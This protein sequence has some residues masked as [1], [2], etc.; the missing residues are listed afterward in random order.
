MLFETRTGTVY[1]CGLRKRIVGGTA[2]P[3]AWNTLPQVPWHSVLTA[4]LIGQADL[5]G[6]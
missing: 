5:T 1:L 6:Q 3:V 4:S 2:T